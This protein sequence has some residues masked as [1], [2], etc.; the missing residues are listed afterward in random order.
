MREYNYDSGAKHVEMR[1][2]LNY[3]LFIRDM[4]NIA[5]VTAFTNL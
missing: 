1:Y 2:E 5:L 4:I 3:L